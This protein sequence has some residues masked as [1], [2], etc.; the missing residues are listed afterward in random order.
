MDVTLV[1]H[2]EE[3]KRRVR[4]DDWWSAEVRTWQDGRFSICFRFSS[5]TVIEFKSCHVWCFRED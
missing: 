4:Q 1:D 3:F 5:V 2:H